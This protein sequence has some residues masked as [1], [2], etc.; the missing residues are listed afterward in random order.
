M[1]DKSIP[2]AN[3]KNTFCPENVFESLDKYLSLVCQLNNNSRSGR[4]AID[5]RTIGT[6]T[7]VDDT[8]NKNI[9]IVR[10]GT[11]IYF[12]CKSN[13]KWGIESNFLQPYEISIILHLPENKEQL[14]AE[15]YGRKLS[16]G[17]KKLF[18]A[19]NYPIGRRII[20]HNTE[21]PYYFCI[22][23]ESDRQTI[24]FLG[25][26]SEEIDIFKSYFYPN[27]AVFIALNGLPLTHLN[28]LA[29]NF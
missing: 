19:E 1:T 4:K 15:F 23:N 18:Q 26:D 8:Q 29:S 12:A 10:D 11:T 16:F 3:A 2:H 24:C 25:F 28:Q 20:L 22:S 13:G 7:I 17:L 9:R 5:T 21:V 6:V 14:Y 27:Q